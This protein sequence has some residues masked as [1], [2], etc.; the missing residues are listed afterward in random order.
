MKYVILALLVGCVNGQPWKIAVARDV[1]YQ[2]PLPTVSVA[3][4]VAP[5]AATRWEAVND[6]NIEEVAQSV[7]TPVRA[8]VESALITELQ[9]RGFAVAARGEAKVDCKLTKLRYTRRSYGWG[10]YGSHNHFAEVDFDCQLGQLRGR[11]FKE[12]S[13]DTLR[14]DEAETIG[15]ALQTAVSQLSA[16][17]TAV[18]PALEYVEQAALYGTWTTPSAKARGAFL[19]GLAGSEGEYGLN[20]EEPRTRAAALLSL[21]MRQKTERL[22]A[23]LPD[24]GAKK[25]I[26]QW[27]LI[28]A[29]QMAG[30]PKPNIAT[31]ALGP[32]ALRLYQSAP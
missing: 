9:N 24:I 22:Q 5:G 32:D 31:S 23:M 14:K 27:A 29:L 20:D 25:N 19:V 28:A 26:E 1:K 6:G 10:Q 16:R 4:A 30:A 17:L 7:E 13:F 2:A 3:L 21:G 18:K 15:R 12:G 8:V 11:W